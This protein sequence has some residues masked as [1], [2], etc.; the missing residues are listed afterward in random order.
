MSENEKTVTAPAATVVINPQRRVI[1]LKRKSGKK[2]RRR[3]SSD[4]AERLDRWHR[5]STDAVV[6]IYDGLA[7]GAHTYRKKSKKSAKK[8]RDGRVR[9]ALVNWTAAIADSGATI[10]KAPNDFAKRVNRNRWRV[11]D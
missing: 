6:R 9:D 5:G 4:A 7:E 11:L 3:Y 8:K 1:V 10:S 2:R